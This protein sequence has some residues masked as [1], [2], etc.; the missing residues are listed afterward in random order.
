MHPLLIDV[1]N[2]VDEVETEAA[3]LE[4]ALV[5][6]DRL[7]MQRDV[8]GW[9]LVQGVASVVEKVYGGYE[10]AMQRIASSVDGNRVQHV[11]GWHVA[12]LR[13]MS[14]PYQDIRPPFL[15]SDTLEILNA[16]RAFRHR[17]RNTYGS[18]LDVDKT[19]ENARKIQG[20]VI[21]FRRDLQEL[22]AYLSGEP[23]GG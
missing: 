17:E 2:E 15:K 9:V 14:R 1:F 13:R 23:D 19:L 22:S 3:K 6:I 5:I 20:L 4:E 18:W 10:N 12:L 11:D 16:L 7:E 8:V 21:F